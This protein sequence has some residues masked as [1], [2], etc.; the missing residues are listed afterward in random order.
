EL[1]RARFIYRNATEL[2]R[3]FR[4]SFTATGENT[5]VPRPSTVYEP[6]SKSAALFINTALVSYRPVGNLEFA[7]GR[8]QLPAGVNVPDLA[9]FTKSRNQLGFY[10]APT[11]L[12]ATWWGR[13]YQFSSYAF[14][15]GG[16]ERSGSRESGGGALAEVDLFGKHRTIVGLNAL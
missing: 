7:I 10:D 3:G 6:P 14:R 8:D 13:R 5:D 9:S 4:F 16:N 1:A 15:P 11:Q 12:K 2:G